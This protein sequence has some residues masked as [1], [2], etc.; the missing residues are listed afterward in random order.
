MQHSAGRIIVA[1]VYERSTTSRTIRRKQ[2][3]LSHPVLSST[4]GVLGLSIATQITDLKKNLADVLLITPVLTW[5]KPSTH[6]GGVR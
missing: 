1:L 4:N 3:R 2:E 5:D 6:R